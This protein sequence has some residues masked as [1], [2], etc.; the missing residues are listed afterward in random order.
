MVMMN[1]ELY[2]LAHVFGIEALKCGPI[3][4]LN[5]VPSFRR[6]ALALNVGWRWMT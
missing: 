3:H 6:K 4:M 5:P 2:N 1:V